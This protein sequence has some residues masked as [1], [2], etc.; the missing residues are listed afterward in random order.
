MD[1]LGRSC[2]SHLQGAN[3]NQGAVKA[4]TDAWTGI[5]QGNVREDVHKPRCVRGVGVLRLHPARDFGPVVSHQTAD[6]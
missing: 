2:S 6:D 1:K 4:S 3:I 5:A